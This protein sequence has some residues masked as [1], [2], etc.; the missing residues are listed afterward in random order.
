MH[1]LR[2]VRAPSSI[3]CVRLLLP[4]VLAFVLPSS[5]HA[6]PG[7]EV[8]LFPYFKDPGTQGVFLMASRDGLTFEHLNGGRPIFTVPESV[9]RDPSIVRGPDDLFHMV[10]TSG[11]KSIGYANSPDLVSWSEPRT[12]PVWEPDDNVINTWAPELFYD[13]VEEEFL[14]VWAST[15]PRPLPGHGVERARP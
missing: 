4:V 1:C 7:G 9:T 14:I 13:D 3:P 2:A 12:I 8:I 11:A 15:G 6:L 5:I 10:W